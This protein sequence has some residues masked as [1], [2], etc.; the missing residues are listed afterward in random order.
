[1]ALNKYVVTI[2]YVQTTNFDFSATSMTCKHNLTLHF[3]PATHHDIYV[4]H[5]EVFCWYRKTRTIV[6]RSARL[7]HKSEKTREQLLLY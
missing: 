6:Q 4:A 1:M 7:L 3:R 5:L 2:I